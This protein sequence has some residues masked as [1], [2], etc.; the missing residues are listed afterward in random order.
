MYEFPLQFAQR[1]SFPLNDLIKLLES[2]KSTYER[3]SLFHSKFPLQ[4]EDIVPGHIQF[5]AT[6]DGKATYLVTV[7]LKY[8]DP[9]PLIVVPY[10]VIT[11]LADFGYPDFREVAVV[12]GG[13]TVDE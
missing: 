10:N 8:A 12:V 11:T 13:H 7:H 2:G 4:H 3:L 1:T 6:I 9:H 5:L